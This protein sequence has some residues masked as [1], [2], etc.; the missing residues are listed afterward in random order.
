MSRKYI[1]DLLHEIGAT[2]IPASAPIYRSSS[3]APF[4]SDIRNRAADLEGR[5]LFAFDRSALN[6]A[7]DL[8]IDTPDR[9]DRLVT[10]VLQ[11]P[12]RLFLEAHSSDMMIVSRNLRGLLSPWDDVDKN[13]QRWGVFVDIFGR[14]RARFHAI[15]RISDA[16]WKSDPALSALRPTIRTFEG[17]IP[18]MV[19]QSLRL[20]PSRSTGDID[21]SRHVG[22]SRAEFDTAFFRMSTDTDPVAR[23][24]ARLLQEDPGPRRRGR[25][26][27]DAWRAMRLRDVIRGEPI[28]GRESET[29]QSERNLEVLRIGIPVIAML[30]VLTAD[31]GDIATEPRKPERRDRKAGS[32]SRRQRGQAPGLRIVT[33]NLEDREMQRI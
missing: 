18:D 24:A 6:A 30:A 15:T 25:I 31:S 33:L 8:R 22:M 26:L 11:E 5:E 27:D 14:G 21:I 32:G 20:F 10:A 17:S 16:L 9:V 29:T 28:P 2:R 19:L 4:V 13:D 23:H 3:V 7:A 1:A 12:R